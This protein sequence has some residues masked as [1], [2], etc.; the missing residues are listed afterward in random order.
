MNIHDFY[1]SMATVS[2]NGSIVSLFPAIL[3]IGGNLV[4][5]QNKQIMFL[6]IPFLIIS[7]IGYQ[8]YLYRMN[9]AAQIRKNTFNSDRVYQSLFE[10]EELLVLLM[11]TQSAN[12]L[13]YYPD[14][15]EAGRIKQ[16]RKG[17]HL[18]RLT[19][20]YALY[21]SAG[22]VEGYFKVKRGNANLKIEVYCHDNQYLGCY[23]KKKITWKNM[24]EEL[25]DA[26]NHSLGVIEGSSYFMDKKLVSP[27]RE[28]VGRLRRGWMPV[29]W[30]ERFPEPN[31]PVLTF[32]KALSNQ[33]KLIRISF[34]INEF[35]IE[36]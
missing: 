3:I 6:S 29:E 11:N 19:K 12:V 33:D 8:T 34:L 20:I 21:N 17:I 2:L 35:F 28:E 25:F 15:N 16:I 5:F 10:P 32:N 26:E 27:S 13:F 7:W 23:V 24:I 4:I 31:T 22:R 1:R 18:F 36:R 9:Q 30:S 14:G